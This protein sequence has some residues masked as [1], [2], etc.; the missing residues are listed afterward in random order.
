M[1]DTIRAPGRNLTV[2]ETVKRLNPQYFGVLPAPDQ[3]AS[4][5]TK[6]AYLASGKAAQPKKR[7]KVMNE[8]A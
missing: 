8:P 7:K 1:S 3:N 4:P 2:G 6:A 5:E